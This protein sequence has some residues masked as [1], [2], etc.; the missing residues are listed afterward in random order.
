MFTSASRTSW[1]V[2][3]SLVLMAELK[4]YWILFWNTCSFTLKLRKLIWEEIKPQQTQ[5]QVSEEGVQWC[6]PAL[7]LKIPFNMFWRNVD[8]SV[9][10]RNSSCNLL[11]ISNLLSTLLD[12]SQIFGFIP[13]LWI[14]PISPP[15]KFFHK[16]FAISSFPSD[17]KMRC[18]Q[19]DVVA[20]A[21]LCILLLLK[22][23]LRVS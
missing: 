21:V 1:R 10:P 4:P 12:S 14:H 13:N 19:K 11:K 7:F 20:K 9:L 2:P 3:I 22:K 16:T 5:N 23:I 8:W 6:I 18:E 17:W 15:D